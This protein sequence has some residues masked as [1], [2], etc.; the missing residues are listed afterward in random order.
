MTDAIW[1]YGSLLQMENPAAPGIFATIAEVMD[2]GGPRMTRDSKEVTSHSSPDGFEEFIMTLKR[3][4]EVTFAIN[5]VPT[6]PTHDGATGLKARYDDGA[7]TNFKI[8]LPDVDSSVWAFGG[9]VQGLEFA[10]GVND[11]LTADVTVKP[12]GAVTLTTP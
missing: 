11:P 2:I 5:F 8:I 9:Y 10:E 12:S 7:F 4:G 3:S 1:A 6:D